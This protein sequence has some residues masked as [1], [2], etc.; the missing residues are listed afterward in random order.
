MFEARSRC[1]SRLWTPEYGAD[2]WLTC[3][4]RHAHAGVHRAQGGSWVAAEAMP[5]LAPCNVH[6]SVS[7]AVHPH[8][9]QRRAG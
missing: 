1:R 7:H 5:D 4:L 9:L 6:T 3:T 2:S 8:R